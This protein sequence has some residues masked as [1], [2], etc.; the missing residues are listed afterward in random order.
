[1]IKMQ[2]IG[3]LGKDAIINNVHGRNVINF[4]IAHSE[5]YKDSQGNPR[6][7]TIWV[8]CAY[9]TER[10]NILPYL[11]KSTHVFVEGSP[12][13]RLFTTQDGKQGAALS[14]RLS[15]IQLLTHKSLNQSKDS[16]LK[17]SMLQ[18][19]FSSS[20]SITEENISP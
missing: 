1:M 16:S 2:I 11:K 3:H 19:D 6:E 14:L 9:W 20:M 13:I 12:D 18:D 7:R 4:N 15:N 5:K 8:E 17:K 10:L